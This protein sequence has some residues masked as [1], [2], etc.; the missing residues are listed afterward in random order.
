MKMFA[1]EGRDLSGWKTLLDLVETLFSK[2]GHEQLRA[3]ILYARQMPLTSPIDGGSIDLEAGTG[4]NW[5]ARDNDL[6]HHWEVRRIER[7]AASWRNLL[8]SEM[9]FEGWSDAEC[10]I[11][12]TRGLVMGIVSRENGEDTDSTIAIIHRYEDGK[13]NSSVELSW[14]CGDPASDILAM[15]DDEIV[16]EA[17]KRGWHLN[18][19]RPLGYRQDVETGDLVVRIPTAALAAIDR[20]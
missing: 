5:N 1:K 2:P 17:E 8:P 13:W 14:A 6:D 9:D 3:G 10:T 12:I 15:T 20:D 4:V 11:D 7:L 19:V 16:E 18:G